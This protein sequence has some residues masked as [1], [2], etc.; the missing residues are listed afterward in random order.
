VNRRIIRL[1]K[2][3]YA[4]EPVMV[5]TP[6]CQ[7]MGLLAR[8]S[9]LRPLEDW[10]APRGSLSEKRDHLV[11]HLLTRYP[12]PDFLFLGFEPTRCEDEAH[13]LGDGWAVEVLA[14]LG[15]GLSL[16]TLVGTGTLPTPLTRR[17][18]HDF[19]QSPKDMRPTVAL[20]QTQIAAGGGDPELVAPLVR[21]R[22]GRLHPLYGQT[23][24][25]FW[26]QVIRW[27]CRCPDHRTLSPSQWDAL[28][29]WIELRKRQSDPIHLSGRS[30]QAVLREVNQLGI[31]ESRARGDAFSASGIQTWEEGQ[32]TLHEI[33]TPHELH[34]EGEAL[35]HCVWSYQDNIRSHE[36]AI[37]SLRF[38]GRST[39]TVE[40]DLR[41]GRIVQ[42]RGF[43]NRI[44]HPTERDILKQW[45]K[46]NGLT[47]AT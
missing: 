6:H 39:L 2:H 1:V 29:R 11:R 27:L 10:R 46:R 15:R 34:R 21:N 31:A 40:V 18:C 20:R 19:L 12:V 33:L 14:C 13:I 5:W 24:E 17:M 22:L 37:W 36:I 43:A 28:L 8:D 16:R 7:W 3:V 42:A 41:F 9:W 47:L 44:C 25:E 26:D 45:A 35:H 30:V 38:D 23:N 4:Y 32:W